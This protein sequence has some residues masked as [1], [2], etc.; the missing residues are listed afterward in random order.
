VRLFLVGPMGAGKSEV[1]RELSRRLGIPLLDIDKLVEEKLG[2][3]ISEVFILKGEEAFR[4]AE[5]EV[6]KEA[7]AGGPAV[8]ACGGGAVLRPDNVEAMRRAG[9]VVYLA[10]SPKEAARRIGIAD[11][12]PLLEGADDLAGCLEEIIA[13]REA[14]YRAAAHAMVETEGRGIQEVAEEVER[15]WRASR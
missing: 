5:S 1:G 3:S 6:L 4:Q 11:G 9:V 13:E 7:A 15:V 12:R 10:V 14:L 8:V 2:I